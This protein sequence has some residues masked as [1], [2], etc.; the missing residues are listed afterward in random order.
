MNIHPSVLS[1]WN[2]M[3]L[4]VALAMSR[5]HST[6]RIFQDRSIQNEAQVVFT[7]NALKL[8][9]TINTTTYELNFHFV[10]LISQSVNVYHANSS[11]F[12]RYKV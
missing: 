1:E 10:Q 12:F 7:P 11:A 4:L 5:N 2:V 9:F 8:V 3:V 6:D